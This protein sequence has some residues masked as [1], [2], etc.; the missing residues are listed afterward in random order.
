[1][2]PSAGT[3]GYAPHLL[4]L[5]MI[6]IWG[7]SYV[8]VKIA[9]ASLPPL[10][11]V[12]ARFALAVLCLAPIVVPEGRDALRRTRAS[13]GL[14]GAVLLLGYALQ[15]LGM[16]ETTAS[17][18]GFLAGLIVLVVAIGGVLF[19]HAPLH[20]TTVVGLLLGFAGL[21]PL[22]MTG[23]DPDVRTNT[24]RG[25]LLQVASSIA[26]AVHIL[27]VSRLSPRGA[28]LQFCLWQ[29]AVV[30]GGAGALHVALEDTPTLAP[31]G[32]AT[33]L[34]C[35]AYLGVLA[36]ALGIAVQSRVQP[37]IQPTH[38]AA[39]F[40]MQPVFAALAGS[41]LLGDVLGPRQVLG[42][43]LIVGG[44]LLVGWRR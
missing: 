20:A 8:A 19:L 31:L 43:A 22:C 4:L 37:R 27:L 41:L 38:V 13:G 24:L 2:R 14:T 10:A 3:A 30:A 29:L 39:L 23:A 44:V 33:L 12:A 42:G 17:M 21:V 16:T 18:G 26:Y 36:T 25:V 7:G 34:G 32:D 1:M 40:A 9:L 35:V 15:T 11:L 5:A 6:A 28:E